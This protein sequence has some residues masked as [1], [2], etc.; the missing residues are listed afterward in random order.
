[1]ENQP[2][3][4]KEI[5][6]FRHGHSQANAERF[7][8]IPFPKFF[9]LIRKVFGFSITIKLIQILDMLRGHNHKYP[10]VDKDT[11]LEP[12]GIEQAELTGEVLAEKEIFPDLILCSDFLRTRQ[13]TNG[14]IK[15]MEKKLNRKLEV[16]VLYSTLIV[17]RDSGYEYGYPLSYYPVLFPETNE[18]YQKTPKLDFRPPGGE[19]IHDV[20]NNRIPELKKILASLNFKTLFIVGHG[21][22]NS[23]V[24]SL[25]TGED[26][27]NVRIGS[28]NLGVYKFTSNGESDKWELDPSYSRGKAIDKSI[29]F[30]G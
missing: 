16:H 19:S 1:M 6:L 21:V 29:P 13:T 2:Y 14:I 7:R 27:E 18:I 30:S 5:Y 22:T 20:R 4:V 26:I 15:G 3:P 23:T 10:T 8:K 25:L 11:P 28:P 24:V 12:L 17:E 9:L